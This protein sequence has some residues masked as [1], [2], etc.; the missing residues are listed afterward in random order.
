MAIN[1]MMQVGSTLGG[2]EL[3]GFRP[4]RLSAN[5]L[6]QIFTEATR[7]VRQ[8]HRPAAMGPECRACGAQPAAQ[9]RGYAAQVATW[10]RAHCPSGVLPGLA[11]K[12]AQVAQGRAV[13]ESAEGGSPPSGGARSA[14]VPSDFWEMPAWGTAKTDETEVLAVLTVGF[15]AV[16]EISRAARSSQF[17]GRSSCGVAP[18]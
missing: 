9:P 8:R 12:C 10:N 7:C 3:P 2:T 17:I 14:S 5:R 1:A 4:R 13:S 6:V 18:G 16:S 11:R 15:P